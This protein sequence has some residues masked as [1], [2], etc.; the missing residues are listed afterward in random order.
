MRVQP[1]AAKI[2]VFLEGDGMGAP[3]GKKPEPVASYRQKTFYQRLQI[4]PSA[5]MEDV[6]RA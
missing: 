1:G 2:G 6:K 5:S 4:G 3:Q